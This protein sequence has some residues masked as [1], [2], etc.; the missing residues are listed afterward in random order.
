MSLD[1]DLAQL[2]LRNTHKPH[3]LCK[4]LA[5]DMWEFIS[6]PWIEGDRLCILVRVPGDPT[7]CFTADALALDPEH[8]DCLCVAAGKDYYLTA[9]YYQERTA[10]LDQ[11][12]AFLWKG[13]R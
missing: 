5:G 4:D 12:P 9:A 1:L 2:A 8:Q 10:R 11:S 7:S 6:Y 3:R 13:V